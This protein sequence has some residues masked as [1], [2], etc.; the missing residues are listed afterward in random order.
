MSEEALGR[1][2]VLSRVRSRVLAAARRW[3]PAAE[4]E[5]VAQE[6][7]LLLATKYA[8][9]AAAEEL[10]ALGARI[11]HFKRS[12]HWRKAGRRGALGEAPLPEAPDGASDPIDAIAS[13]APDPEAAAVARQRLALLLEAAARLD[14]R[15]RSLLQRKLEGASF[16]EI[17]AELGRPVNTVYSWD[18]RCHARL[19]ALLGDRWSFVSGSG[20]ETRAMEARR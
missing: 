11:V 13:G 6:A 14:G 10:V 2:E 7:L 15:C 8:H 19:R 4:A 5:D 12:A 1:D 17:A 9:V 18:Y 20:T 3:L 16:V